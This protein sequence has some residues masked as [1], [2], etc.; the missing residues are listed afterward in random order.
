MCFDRHMA[1]LSRSQ[2]R[3]SQSD[4]VQESIPEPSSLVHQRRPRGRTPAWVSGSGPSHS[5]TAPTRAQ[6]LAPF[7]K[8]V[9]GYATVSHGRLPQIRPYAFTQTQENCLSASGH[10][11]PKRN[12]KRKTG[13]AVSNCQ[14]TT[15]VTLAHVLL[16]TRASLPRPLVSQG[17]VNETSSAI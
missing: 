3:G 10:T 4:K 9:H 17:A 15:V 6:R 14:V 12:F 7:Q 1:V 5:L 8:E 16:R 2:P 11:L 13:G